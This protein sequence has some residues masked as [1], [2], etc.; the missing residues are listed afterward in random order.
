MAGCT[1]YAA[2]KF[3]IRGMTKSAAM[4]LGPKGIRVNSVHPGM[5]DTPMTRVHGGDAAMEYG[6]SKVAAAS[7]S[8]TP[9][10]SRRLYV[11]LA[12]DESVVHQRRRARRSTAASPPPTP[13]AADQPQHQPDGVLDVLADLLGADRPVTQETRAESQTSLITRATAMSSSVGSA[14]STYRRRGWRA[15]SIGVSCMPTPWISFGHRGV[16]E[17]ERPGQGLGQLRVASGARGWRA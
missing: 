4:E 17:H 1:A 5:I 6:A 7:A 14:P 3:A 10:T 2:T 12:S 9:R 16:G 15:S 13:S 8:A 11:F